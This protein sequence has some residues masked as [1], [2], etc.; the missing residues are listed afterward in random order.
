MELSSYR[1][2]LQACIKPGKVNGRM[3]IRLRSSGSVFQTENSEMT[4]SSPCQSP[5]DCTL[6]PTLYPTK[7]NIL[8][9]RASDHVP[10]H[11]GALLRHPQMQQLHRGIVATR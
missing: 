11:A 7:H 1:R 5:V 2:V 10:W 8:W 9:T 3:C 4:R 6:L